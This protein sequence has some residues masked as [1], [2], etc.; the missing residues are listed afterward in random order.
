MGVEPG[1]LRL[2]PRGVDHNFFHPNRRQADFWRNHGLDERIVF[3]Y[4]GRVSKEK[5]VERLLDVFLQLREHG[6]PAGL[7]IVGDGPERERLQERYQHPSI[8]FT[9]FLGGRR[10]A[11]AY[12]SA[13]VFVFPSTTDTFGNAVLEAQASGLPAIVSDRGGPAE[14]VACHESGVVVEVEQSGAL[15]GAMYDLVAQPWLRYELRERAIRNA[16]ERSWDALFDILWS[17]PRGEGP[18]AADLPDFLEPRSFSA[19]VATDKAEVA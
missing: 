7:A 4:V 6:I 11:T 13:D 2:M 18:A 14:I 10:L 9:G 16:A 1:K 12:A 5:N 17:A 15:S 19:P 3:L 8:L